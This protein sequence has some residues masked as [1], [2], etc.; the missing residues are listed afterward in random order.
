MPYLLRM[1]L[2]GCIERS[3]FRERQLPALPPWANP[4]AWVGHELKN[5][6][7]IAFLGDLARTGCPIFLS[8]ATG[9]RQHAWSSVGGQFRS[10]SGHSG[11]YYSVISTRKSESD[12]SET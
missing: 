1:Q 4:W 3:R 5:C 8:R 12:P 9:G 10:V 2:F 11:L 6:V 7:F